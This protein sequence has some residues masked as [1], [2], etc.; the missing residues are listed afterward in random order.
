VS[1]LLGKLEARR[2]FS[3]GASCAKTGAATAAV[4]AT[5]PR[6][7]FFKNERR[8]IRNLLEIIWAIYDAQKLEY[9]TADLSLKPAG[10]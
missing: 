6:L 1:K 5:A 3:V 2:Q 9:Y 7:A 10:E 8:C 4:P